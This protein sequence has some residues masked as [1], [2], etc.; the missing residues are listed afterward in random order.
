MSVPLSGSHRSGLEAASGAA[1]RSLTLHLNGSDTALDVRRPGLQSGTLLGGPVVSLVDARH[2]APRTA[3]MIENGLG[4][5]EANT[6]ALKTSRDRP[7]DIVG[8]P[9][10]KA[11]AKRL[12]HQIIEALLRF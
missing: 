6:Q 3:D 2:S 10:L 11:V 4:D 12:F 9:R 7:P 5:L 8:A 1:Q